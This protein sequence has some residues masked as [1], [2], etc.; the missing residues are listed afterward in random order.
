VSD[1]SPVRIVVDREARFLRAPDRGPTNLR[2]QCLRWSEFTLQQIFALNRSSC[3]MNVPIEFKFRD[4]SARPTR[5][6]RSEASSAPVLVWSH[7]VPGRAVLPC[8][9]LCF[10][11]GE[12]HRFWA[13][14]ESGAHGIVIHA[15]GNHM[16]MQIGDTILCSRVAA[17]P[18]RP[19]H[20]N[21]HVWP[22][23][24][25]CLCTRE[26][27][28]AQRYVAVSALR[29]DILVLLSCGIVPTCDSLLS[30]THGLF[31]QLLA[32]QQGST[33]VGAVRTAVCNTQQACLVA[34]WLRHGATGA[35]I[36]MLLNQRVGPMPPFC[37]VVMEH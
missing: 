22:C 29:C 11:P 23:I 37:A 5:V 1:L 12:E 28:S 7:A 24:S 15:H 35:E 17:T 6:N 10:G 27:V 2:E 8:G 30:D 14:A 19:A 13:L 9:A 32:S 3:A 21:E 18:C 31:A 4:P 34:E 36:A 16:D 26:R 25:N 33:I 20:V